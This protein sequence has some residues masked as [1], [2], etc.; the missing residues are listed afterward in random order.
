[1][2]V[3]QTQKR[4]R[5]KSGPYSP[6]W[7]I[8]CLAALC[9]A[10]LVSTAAAAD[11]R[12]A[13]QEVASSA[14]TVAA[15]VNSAIN[16]ARKDLEIARA[17]YAA[18]QSHG[19]GKAE[20]LALQAKDPVVLHLVQWLGLTRG[21]PASLPAIVRWIDENPGWP[22]RRQLVRRVEES[23]GVDTS[24]DLILS[25][26]RRHPPVSSMGKVR[27]AEAMI[28]AGDDTKGTALLRAAW[29][30]G[31]F[32]RTQ[33]KEILKKHGRLLGTEDHVR[34]LDRLLWDGRAEDARR[35]L[36]K[37]DP[38][39]RAL[40]EARLSLRYRHGNV[41]RAVARVPDALQRDPGLL[42]ERVRWRRIKGKYDAAWEVFKDLPD[43]LGRAD[44]W[45]NERSI[46]ARRALREGAITDAY[47]IVQG[48]GLD[49]GAAYAEAEWMAG[50]IALRFLRDHQVA[51]RHFTSMSSAVSYPV[52]KARGAYWAARAAEELK[53]K[54][55]AEVWDRIA[56]NYPTTFY[57]QLAAARLGPDTMLTLPPDP[58]PTPDEVADFEKH[59][60]VRAIRLLA[61]LGLKDEMRPFVMQLAEFRA[62]AGWRHLAAVL[63]RSH[64]R[65]ELAVAVAKY[66]S[67]AGFEL[68][69]AGYPHFQPP[70]PP[71]GAA[72]RD[73]PE[74]PLVL[75]VV[76]Q[77]SAFHPEATS[78]AGARGLMQI[79]PATAQLVAKTYKMVYAPQK[80][81]TEPE[82]N[83]KLGQAYLRD[84]LEEFSGS[85]VLALSAYNAGPKR[86]REWIKANGDPRGTLEDVVDWIEMIPFEETRNYVQRVLEN[87]Q[88][89][90]LR[91]NGGSEAAAKLIEDLRR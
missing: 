35:L 12:P 68:A 20:V 60:L 51:L 42:Y 49:G 66:A 47:R 75:A 45:W 88:V 87:L 79:M 63:A 77:E 17:A 34:R 57:G 69:Q 26:F 43:E 86:A 50:W 11:N 72:G 85:Y 83:L 16:F 65:A 78:S 54:A 64:G 19:W 21:A 7:R 46:L 38:P 59:E 23:I 8:S 67:R 90:R 40:A 9:G 55:T 58:Q 48:H 84:L 52:S 82:Y 27:F 30:E 89:Y 73:A 74:V 61:A 29:T 6:E 37:V 14:E 36:W 31:R 2:D 25:W 22:L 28:A 13:Q 44:L 53:D 70:R 4:E 33:E 76:R 24:G 41:D 3:A 39:H 71:K 5:A 18:I 91:L 10:F 1:M 81:T 62:S 80:L 15:S 56:A 32:N